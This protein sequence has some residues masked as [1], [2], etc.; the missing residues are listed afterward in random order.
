MTEKTKRP[1][2]KDVAKQAGVSIT[3][4]SQ[5]LNNKTERFP[6][7]TI[8][9]VLVARD[10]LGYI[11]NKSAQKLR[12]TAKPMI[13]VLVPSL[14]NP[15]FADLM[16]SMEEHAADRVELIFQAAGD[17][18]IETS[19]ENLV[20]RGI[21][22]LVIARTVEKA[23]ETFKMLKQRGVAVTVLDQAGDAGLSDVLTTN[24]YHGGKLV[25]EFLI[26][27]GHQ[28]IAL[29]IPNVITNNM[30]QRING[31]K[32]CW[33]KEG[34]ELVE[35]TTA[36]SK[37]GGLAVSG[38]VAKMQVTAV[39]TLNDELG[40]GLSRGLANIGVKVPD[41]I[42]IIGYDNTD[43]SEFVTPSL[44]TVTQPVWQL[45]QRALDMVIDRLQHPEM[46]LQ[47]EQL[48]IVRVVERES[49]RPLRH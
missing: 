42:S 48:D 25:G 11:P 19:I 27:Q 16:Q 35:V 46:A 22:G 30:Q 31:F 37:H 43:F 20:E 6:S 1:S 33:V 14:R 41:E 7:D 28:R 29:V 10:K 17:D 40:I 8:T 12:G 45:G 32:D 49:T 38:K 15:F 34:R 26:R 9:R 36:L 39:F 24:D 13:G 47:A 23:D 5:I 4:V 44:T 3:T 18:A 21:N 2:I